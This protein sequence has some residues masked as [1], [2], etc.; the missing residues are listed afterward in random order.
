MNGTVWAELTQFTLWGAQ[1]V[2]AVCY[3]YL[4]LSRLFAPNERLRDGER[5]PLP[6]RLLGG[7]ELVGAIALIFPVLFETGEALVPIAAGCLAAA[8]ILDLTFRWRR[9]RAWVAIGTLLLAAVSVLIV[10]LRA[11]VAPR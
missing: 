8:T 6:A 2:L 10:I 9:Q 4:G 5:T 3:G 7:A 1:F 11:G